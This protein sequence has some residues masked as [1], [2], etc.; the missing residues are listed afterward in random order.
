MLLMLLQCVCV[1]RSTTE[2]EQLKTQLQV[3]KIEKEKLKE[4]VACMQD[5]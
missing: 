2:A 3:L 1:H 4:L 5:R